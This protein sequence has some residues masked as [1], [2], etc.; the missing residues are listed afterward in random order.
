MK[1][2]KINLF[3][4]IE[5]YISYLRIQ[6]NLS[7]FTLINYSK[8]L[9]QLLFFLE[10]KNIDNFSEISRNNI[11]MLIGKL[12]VKGLSARTL[13]RKLSSWRGFYNWLAFEN[14]LNVNPTTGIRVPKRSKKLPKALSVDEAVK[15]VSQFEI[16]E[17]L[18]KTS[19]LCDNAMFELLY[20]SGLRVSELVSLD[21]SYTKKNNYIST[22]WLNLESN[23]V[24]IF[25][26]GKKRRIVPVGKAAINSIKLWIKERDKL[27]NFMDEP[28]LFISSRGKRITPRLVQKRIKTHAKNVGI[29]SNISPHV[30][31]HSFASHLLQS[32]G[33]LRAV[34]EL[35]GHASISSTQIYT[36]L[37]YQRLTEVYDVTHPRAKKLTTK[38]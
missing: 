16:N 30:L 9:H 27:I 36:S 35:L 6:R 1:K 7:N 22:S 12:Y 26:K 25:G 28:A 29:K 17:K 38:L 8:D 2:N 10:E 32:S 3:K 15:L 13:A 24:N 18:N 34:Q 21:K 33:D 11:Q 4:K 14:D 31:R 37:D 23:E 20:S 5:E 19:F